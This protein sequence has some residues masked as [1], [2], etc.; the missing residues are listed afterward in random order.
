[1]LIHERFH[2]LSADDAIAMLEKYLNGMYIFCIKENIN[3]PL[4]CDG[5]DHL[6]YC[7]Q[8]LCGGLRTESASSIHYGCNVQAGHECNWCVAYVMYDVRDPYT[9]VNVTG[10][11]ENVTYDNASMIVNRSTD[12][13]WSN[14]LSYAVTSSKYVIYATKHH[15]LWDQ[16][17]PTSKFIS[18]KKI[19]A[20]M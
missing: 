16:W 11:F 7:V 17:N 9:D 3:C 14:I 12:L 10:Y 6:A 19:L 15:T 18:F 5:I 2:P 8:H 4:S 1:M 20:I 13:F